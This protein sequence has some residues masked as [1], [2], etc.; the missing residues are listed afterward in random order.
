MAG[1]VGPLNVTLSLSPKVDD[2]G[3]RAVTFDEVDEAYAEQMRALRDG[4]VDLLLV[5]TIFD[6]LNA[7]AAI[8]AAND[9][10]A[11]APPCGSASR[12]STAAAARSP[13]RP[14]EA[15]W[16]SIEHADA[17]GGR[18]Q[19]LARRRGD[20]PLRRGARARRRR[21]RSPATRTPVCPTRSAATTRRPGDH[22]RAAR[23]VRRRQGFVNIVG[24][25]CGTTP[26]H[27]CAIAAA[28][29]DL[30]PRSAP[31]GRRPVT[32]FSGLEPLRD[33]AA[34]PGS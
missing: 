16:T 15:F 27:I 24:G 8:A 14:I 23:R 34:T 5:E 32:T 10:G 3:F 1:S 17:A 13:D 11:R 22:E 25:C 26:E 21:S 18:H 4:G 29:R 19:L 2:P 9:V 33:H 20:A 6:T 12:S 31:D 28:V 7:K 30:A